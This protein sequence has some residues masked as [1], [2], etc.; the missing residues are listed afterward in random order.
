MTLIGLYSPVPQSGKSTFA[1]ALL[2]TAEGSKLIKFADGFR[3]MIIEFMADFFPGGAAEVR[4]WLEDERK[5]NAL[6]PELGVTLRHCLQTEGTWGRVSVHP[7]LWVM[8]ARKAIWRAHNAPFIVVDD[9]RMP[10]EFWMLRKLGAVMIRVWRPDAPPTP[11]HQSNHQLEEYAFDYRVT[12]DCC[13]TELAMYARRV[14][15]ELGLVS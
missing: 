9:V 10:N 14:G 4:E 6:I 8:K 7:D 5:D 13:P 2:A 12:N 11:E 3:E 15:W 1:K